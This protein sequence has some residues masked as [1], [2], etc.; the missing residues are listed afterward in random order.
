MSDRVISVIAIAMAIA[1]LCFGSRA[2]PLDKPPVCPKGQHARWVYDRFDISAC[3]SSGRETLSC[4]N[5]GLT[6]EIKAVV[7]CQKLPYRPM[8]LTDAELRDALRR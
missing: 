6:C 4:S 1:V 7:T 5:D 2:W 8:C 3:V